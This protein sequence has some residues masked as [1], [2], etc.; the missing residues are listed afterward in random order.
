MPLDTLVE[1]RPSVFAQDRRNSDRLDVAIWTQLTL[2]QDTEFP[3]RITNMSTIGLM[4]MT[5]SNAAEG[6]KIQL[7]LPEIG[8]IEGR[9]AWR[10]GD[11]IGIE[12]RKP[13][14]EG[15]FLLLTPYCL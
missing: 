12:F 11:R 9:I 3:V 2:G 14:V 7:E 1:S 13:I 4:A 10:L 5:P 15:D 6:A 8:W